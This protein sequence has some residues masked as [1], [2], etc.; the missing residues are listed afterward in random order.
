MSQNLYRTNT[1]QS[2]QSLVSPRAS[3]GWIQQPQPHR[4]SNYVASFEPLP[5]STVARPPAQISVDE[6]VPPDQR[7]HSSAYYG[8]HIPSTASLPPF[9]GMGYAYDWSMQPPPLPLRRTSMQDASNDLMHTTYPPALPLPPQ[10]P[11]IREPSPRFFS[12]ARQR[13]D[14]GKGRATEVHVPPPPAGEIFGL[15]RWNTRFGYVCDICS[16][17]CPDPSKHHPSIDGGLCTD[18][19]GSSCPLLTE[20]ETDVARDPERAMA[21]ANAICAASLQQ[22]Q[23][24]Q[25]WMVPQSI[26]QIQGFE[27]TPPPPPPPTG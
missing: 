12:P 21:T 16:R 23:Q 19:S 26:G 8:F 5:R 4:Q 14:K 3:L 27:G 1:N 17:V 22:Q 9:G 20:V 25:M 13:R 18:T 2:L 15:C 6:N 24:G 7:R 10:P 11:I